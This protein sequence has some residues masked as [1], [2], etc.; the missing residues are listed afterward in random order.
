MVTAAKAVNVVKAISEFFDDYQLS[1]QKCIIGLR[2]AD[3]PKMLCLTIKTL[4]HSIQTHKSL[5]V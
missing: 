3:H 1:W 5:A 4:D 2:R